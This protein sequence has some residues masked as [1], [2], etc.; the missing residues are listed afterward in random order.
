MNNTILMNEKRKLFSL[1]S[2]VEAKKI[3]IYYNFDLIKQLS[4][5]TILLNLSIHD[6]LQLSL[7]LLEHSVK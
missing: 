1:M 4:P 7:H 2:I 6:L 3:L 5:P